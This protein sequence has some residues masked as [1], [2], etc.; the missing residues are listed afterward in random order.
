MQLKRFRIAAILPVLLMIPA[1][2]APRPAAA[3]D[4]ALRDGDTVVFLGDSITAA[5]GYTQV[6]EHYTLMRF[7]DRRVRFVN[8][9]QGG[10]TA[11]GSLE[12]LDRD[13]FD[14]GATVV[15]L[16]FGIND[17]GWGMKADD[18]HRQRYLDAVR[19]IVG[20]CRVRNVRVYFCSP[21]ITAEDP[22]RAESGFL[23]RMA[24]EGLALAKSAGATGTI[25]I[26][27][28]MREI[29][30]R[31]LAANAKEPDPEKHVRLHVADGVHLNDLGQ[32]AMAY[33]MLKGL[34]AP[35]DVSSAAIDA[36]SGTVTSSDGCRITEV[37]VL[38]G[39]AG[40][41]FTRLDQGL[42][43][44]LGTFSGLNYRWIPVPDQ[45]NRYLLTV[46]GLPDGEY[47]ITAGGR[48][49]GRASA[50]RLA[51]GLNISGMTAD[52][53]QPGGP[54][55]AQ[56]R[57]VK[58]LVEARDRVWHGGYERQRFLSGLPGTETLAAAIQDLDSRIVS[59]QRTAARPQPYRFTI[60]RAESPTAGIERRSTVPYGRAGDTA[61]LMDVWLPP[62]AVPRPVPA[63]LCIHGGGWEGGSRTAEYWVN[64]ATRLAREGFAV[65]SIDY[66]LVKRPAP[67]GRAEN[68]WP[69]AYDDCQRAVRFLR[70]HAADY[71][72]DPDRMAAIGDSAG[73]HLVSLLGT[74][75]TRDNSDPE[76][77][78]FSSRV[79][80]VVDIFGPA[81]LTVPLPDI[82]I[83]GITPRELADNFTGPDPAA[84]RAASPRFHIDDRTPPV[85]ILHGTDDAVVPISQSREFHRALTA[86]GRDATLVELPGAGHGFGGADAAKALEE[87][88]R[89]LRRTVA[90][91]SRP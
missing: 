52:P 71:G 1:L 14:A 30:R 90:P 88:L 78:A 40:I 48:A 53:W 57:I 47:D 3:G 55:D 38:P 79:N 28:E 42:P 15:T 80:A 27:R 86:A 18:E 68:A 37:S 25:D 33:A 45:L 59:V 60:S 43:L 84:K 31:I 41:E 5:R 24:D 34:G 75:D 77:A 2:A 74:T 44:N 73:G 62:P 26:Q 85:L 32:L 51:A 4:Y 6:V 54:W 64:I 9:G 56:S 72:I 76:L 46:T 23:Q 35:A 83:F 81:D 89:F 82:N 49:L 66:R 50:A 29:Q 17:I 20:R 70:R 67:G 19:T 63:A 7:P 58:D 69:A 65:F 13:V 8:A 91:R 39:G 11:A 61:L 21:A 12:R 36:A 16:A 22:D 87:I 10:D